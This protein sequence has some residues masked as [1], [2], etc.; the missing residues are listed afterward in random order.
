MLQFLVETSLRNRV[1]VVVLAVLLL[2]GGMWATWHAQLDVF[3]NFAP[4]M[5]VV[6]AQAPGLSPTQVEQLVTLPIEMALSGMP[7][8]DVVRSQSI[9]GLSAV[10]VIFQDGTD[11]FRA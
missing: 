5:V 9:Q 3:P 8:L 2:V 4:P 10:T 6:Q 7:R 11:I 1:V